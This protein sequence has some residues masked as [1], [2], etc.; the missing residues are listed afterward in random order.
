MSIEKKSIKLRINEEPV[1][2]EDLILWEEAPDDEEMVLLELT[3]SGRII[4]VKDENLF[5][6]LTALRQ[7]LEAVSIQI[8]CNGAAENVY[9]SPMQMSMGPGRL[10]YK[11]CMGVQTGVA[12]IVDIFDCD[13]NLKFVTIDEQSK[14]Y[15]EWIKSVMK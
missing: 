12:D 2:V 4:S 14:Y 11:L 3:V 5:S 15:S 13:E 7:E 9:P 10:A 8:L 6:A 1:T